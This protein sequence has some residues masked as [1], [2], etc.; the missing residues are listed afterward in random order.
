MYL[1]NG[2]L[3]DDIIFIAA[4][5][6]RMMVEP[7]PQKPALRRG[8]DSPQRCCSTVLHRL[9]SGGCALSCHP[10][11]PDKL[12]KRINAGAYYIR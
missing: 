1:N 4:K 8:E 6:S 10:L 11:R 2:I 12:L 5:G 9:E 7:S 3:V